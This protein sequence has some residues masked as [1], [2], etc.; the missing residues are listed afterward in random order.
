MV[1]YRVRIKE[2]AEQN[3]LT[4]YRLAKNA[5]LL[6]ATL[7]AIARGG[8]QPTLETIAKIHGALEA[9]LGREVGLEEILEVVRE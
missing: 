3:G 5:G 8:T 1:R 6:P 7:Y 4:L 2:V 9:L